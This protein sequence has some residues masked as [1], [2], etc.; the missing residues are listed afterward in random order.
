MIGEASPSPSG[1]NANNKTEEELLEKINNIN[2]PPNE[3]QDIEPK[4]SEE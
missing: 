2:S 4:K 1:S 3:D